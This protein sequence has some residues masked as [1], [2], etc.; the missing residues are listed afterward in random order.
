PDKKEH[1]VRLSPRAPG[2]HRLEFADRSG[3]TV[4][5]WP[6]EM[7]WTIP[8]GQEEAAELQGRWTM[9]FYVPKG[10]KEVAG[11]ADGPGELQDGDGQ[12]VFTFTSRPD[13]SASQSRRGSRAGCGSSP[14]ARAS[15]FC[16]PSRPTWLATAGSCCCRPRWCGQM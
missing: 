12:K 13:T 11:Y 2:L 16:S 8:A 5:V 7:P 6:A 9:Y 10:T 4:L 14:I 15:G 1:E 3:G